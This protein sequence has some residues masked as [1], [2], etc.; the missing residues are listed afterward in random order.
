M[1]TR[2]MDEGCRIQGPLLPARAL[3]NGGNEKMV[4]ALGKQ[5]KLGLF[6]QPSNHARVEYQYLKPL[7]TALKRLFTS[8]LCLTS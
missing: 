3:F 1:T 2:I 8:C 6:Q 5:Q 7:S 4:E